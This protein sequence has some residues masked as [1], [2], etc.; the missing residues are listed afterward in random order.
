MS[1]RR[2]LVVNGAVGEALSGEN[3]ALRPL[4]RFGFAPADTVP[5]ISEALVR[6]RQVKYE[7]VLVALDLLNAA[8]LGS[9]ERELRLQPTTRVMATSAHSD[10]ELILRAMRSGID[11]FLVRPL[12]SSDVATALERLTQRPSGDGKRGEVIAVF[13]AKGGM[14]TTTL[15]VNLAF[16]LARTNQALRIALVDLVPGQGDVRLALDL[17]ASYDYDDL[18]SRKDRI[19]SDVLFSLLTSHRGVWV[20]P[21]SERL[22]TV[23]PPHPEATGT[24]LNQL[25][26]HFDATVLDCGDLL[27]ENT[28]AAFDASD[29]IVLVTQL[30]IPALR[31]TQRTLQL[32]GRL[33]YRDERL[34]IVVNRLHSGDTV[35]QAE[36]STA[37]G[38]EIATALPNDYR[39]CTK[40]LTRG[41]AVVELEPRSEL[42]QGIA[43]LAKRLA[44]SVAVTTEA[45]T[46]PV[47]KD[48]GRRR[49][50]GLRK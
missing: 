18:L 49:L 13:S 3:G 28:L 37:L 48:Q 33:G 7:L 20:L 14:G 29:R 50:A 16:Q 46:P 39:L 1:N 23:E 6:M 31:G 10:P 30:T 44:P 42:S 8:E 24:I 12:N 5:S 47:G 4:Q 17:K 11:E 36:A 26:A 27:A 40:A 34:Q 43:Q 25:R 9:L 19:D 35:S 22:E 15:A 32:L 45:Q 38:H 21:A 2:V 41:M